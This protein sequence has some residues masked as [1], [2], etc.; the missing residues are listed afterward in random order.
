MMMMCR[1]ANPPTLLLTL[2]RI[3][4]DLEGD[5]SEWWREYLRFIIAPKIL[6]TLWKKIFSLEANIVNTGFSICRRHIVSRLYWLNPW[7][8][9]E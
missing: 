6:L 3:V 9:H 4:K 5:L 2:H 8:S 1:N 7:I